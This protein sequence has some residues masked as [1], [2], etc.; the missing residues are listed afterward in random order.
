[1]KLLSIIILVITISA[2]SQAQYN[3][4]GSR[5]VR[6]YEYES[7]SIGTPQ[8]LHIHKDSRGILFI[9][10]VEKLVEYDGS[11]MIYHNEIGQPTATNSDPVDGTL[12]ISLGNDFGYMEYDMYGRSHFHSLD[13]L[14]EDNSYYLDDGIAFKGDT[15]FF[16]GK[17]TVVTYVK[18]SNTASVRKGKFG[19]ALFFENEVYTSTPSHVSILTDDSIRNIIDIDNRFPLLDIERISSNEKLLSI[20]NQLI[21]YN[22]VDK[23]YRD[24]KIGDFSEKL[25]ATGQYDKIAT[26][27]NNLFAIA[28]RGSTETAAVALFDSQYQPKDYIGAYSGFGAKNCTHL[29]GDSNE[30]KIWCAHTGFASINVMSPIRY[31]HDSGNIQGIISS[32]GK[33]EDGFIICTSYGAS[34]RSEGAN[35]FYSIKNLPSARLGNMYSMSRIVSPYDNKTKDIAITDGGLFYFKGDEEICMTQYNCNYVVQDPNNLRALYAL[36]FNTVSKLSLLPDMSLKM[37]GSIEVDDEIDFEK[38]FFSSDGMLWAS[39]Y[40][41]YIVRFNPQTQK[42]KTFEIP[43]RNLFFL[44]D[45]QMAYISNANELF[46]FNPSSEE[47]EINKS[48][49]FEHGNDIYMIRPYGNGYFAAI[50]DKFGFCVKNNEGNKFEF[51]PIPTHQLCDKTLI[52]VLALEEDSTIYFFSS[53]NIYSYRTDPQFNKLREDVKA[54]KTYSYNALIRHV[55]TSDSTIFFGTFI[56]E[57][58]KVSLKQNKKHILTIPYNSA[59]LT[60]NYTATCYDLEEKTQF[61]YFLD[62]DSE[63]WSEWSTSR[64]T[65]FTNLW[66]GK[67][68]FRVKAK[69]IYGVESS[70]S[71]YSFVVAPPY[72][73]S[74]WAYILYAALAVLIIQFIVRHY[75]K[76]LTRENERLEEMVEERTKIIRKR[77]EEI[78]SN[79]NYASY[80]QHA[81]LTPEDKI[82]VIFPEHFIMY[83]P[84]SIVSGDFYLVTSYDTKKV[85]IVGDC[86]GHGVSGGFLSMLGMSF[87]RQI[88]SDT[89]NPS[90][91]LAQMREHIIENLHQGNGEIT[92]NQDGMDASVFVI[93]SETN[94]LEFAG[95]NSRLVIIHDGQLMELKGDKMP[96]ST[97]FAHKEEQYTNSSFKLSHG[98]MVYS[99]SDGYIDQFG[100]PD[101]KKFKMSRFRELLVSIADFPIS[102]QC[103]IVNETFDKFKGDHSQTDDV[104]VLGVRI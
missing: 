16:F 39:T 86:T 87:F 67:Y 98:D 29:E 9:S 68:T 10:Q 46:V 84:H 17:S 79:I 33:N 72:Y 7:D 61:S 18:S 6:N 60:F 99:F 64:T 8:T 104:V 54:L 80:I 26:L 65:N 37:D 70:I 69:N 100:G 30:G 90:E 101:Y 51:I 55:S 1:M 75:I 44:L 78:L 88:V 20:S 40:G 74:F 28:S 77:D 36:S 3:K 27:N 42:W 34:F 59:S 66:E 14:L 49:S 32:M 97:H 95:A 47:F 89:Q 83:R 38:G 57:N 19:R 41:D 15:V 21:A 43:I 22:D 23:S 102:R 4:Y 71:E 5:F 24:I 94:V 12:Y 56:D 73:R 53:K 76:S 96:V 50:K 11:S 48:I 31:F 103:D 45:G 52:D 92:R 25:G 93:D 58:G 35:N 91:I 2:L 13:H 62:G 63:E 85:C 82:S 81:A